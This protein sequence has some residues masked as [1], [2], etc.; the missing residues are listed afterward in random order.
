MREKENKAQIL[1]EKV[2]QK[3]RERAQLEKLKKY[4]H[5]M[6]K[7]E[8]PKYDRAAKPLSLKSDSFQNI[9]RDFLPVIGN[10]PFGVTGLKNLGNT[11]YMNSIV[12]CLSNTNQ[13]N[14]FFI[15]G[16][17]RKFLNL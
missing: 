5:D 7:I 10:Q 6:P 11:C 17:Y 2:E 12:Q 1:K 9:Q 14:E 15:T 8:P 4:N 13:L 3:A 16:H